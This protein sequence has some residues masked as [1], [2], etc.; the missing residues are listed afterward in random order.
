ML[1]NV[2]CEQTP[3][4]KKKVSEYFE[5]AKKNFGEE[6]SCFSMDFS[7]SPGG[8]FRIHFEK[9]QKGKSKSSLFYSHFV[10]SSDDPGKRKERED[11]VDHEAE[12]E[13]KTS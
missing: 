5:E 6:G 4:R 8:T 7:E 9:K 11:Q 12:H 2:K 3:I 13:E 1:N 10:P